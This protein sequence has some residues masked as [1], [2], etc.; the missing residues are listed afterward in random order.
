MSGRLGL[1]NVM[2]ERFEI[3]A[4]VER[5]RA[6]PTERIGVETAVRIRTSESFEENLRVESKLG[7]LALILGV[8]G[9]VIIAAFARIKKRTARQEKLR[10]LG[11]GMF[12]EFLHHPLEPRPAFLALS[13]GVGRRAGK[14]KEVCPQRAGRCLGFAGY[15]GS[16]TRWGGQLFFFIAVLLLRRKTK[17]LAVGYA[18][19]DVIRRRRAIPGR[20]NQNIPHVVQQRT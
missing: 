8:A 14:K 5:Q 19:L 17:G 7:P 9:S 2:L 20:S 4:A 1:R 3:I 11:A 10:G 13:V 12:R 18:P 6:E 16:R 15:F